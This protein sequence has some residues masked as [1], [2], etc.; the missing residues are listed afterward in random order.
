MKKLIFIVLLAM[1]VI[2]GCAQQPV[3]EVKDTVTVVVAPTQ[4]EAQLDTGVAEVDNLEADLS[5]DDLEAEFDNFN[6][7]ELEGI[8]F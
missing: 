6:P 8:D 7:D 5:A 3:E 1:L 4:D 2:V